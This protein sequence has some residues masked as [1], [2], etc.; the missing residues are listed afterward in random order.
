M[1]C[2]QA[3]RESQLS[4]SVAATAPIPCHRRTATQ[5]IIDRMPLV[6]VHKIFILTCVK[7]FA[8]L[9]KNIID[10]LPLSLSIQCPRGIALYLPRVIRHDVLPLRILNRPSQSYR[11]I[12][13]QHR[14]EF[15]RRVQHRQRLLFRSRHAPLLLNISID[16][17]N[18]EILVALAGIQIDV[19]RHFWIYRHRLVRRAM[20]VDHVEVS[21]HSFNIV[22]THRI[23][24][25]KLP[26]MCSIIAEYRFCQLGLQQLWHR[27]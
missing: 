15:R 6:V 18:V 12:R 25:H 11:A 23:D 3:D 9:E 21:S 4:L 7:S 5:A 1:H 24:E 26:C 27:R 13:L 2:R 17:I 22:R 10:S 14:R 19:A 16:C 20:A 8:T